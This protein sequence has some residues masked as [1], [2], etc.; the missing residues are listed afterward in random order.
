MGRPE[1]GAGDPPPDPTPDAA[2]D[3]ARSLTPASHMEVDPTMVDSHPPQHRSGD[4][5]SRQPSLSFL[6]DLPAAPPGRY[7][8]TDEI[9]RGGMGVVRGALDDLFGREVALK[10]LLDPLDDQLRARFLEE[11]RVTA[12]LEHPNVVPVH[13]M[14]VLPS[15]EVF[16]AMKRVRGRT[17]ADILDGI[18]EGDSDVA[19]EFSRV[20]LLTLFQQ[21]CMGVHYAHSRGVVHR[22]LKPDNLMVGEYGEVH[23]MDWGVARVLAREEVDVEVA[24]ATIAPTN[25]GMTSYGA[26]VGT[27]SYMPPEQAQGHHDK[28]GPH[29]DVYALGALLYEILT[30][31]PPFLERTPLATL[32]RVVTEVPIPPDERAPDRAIPDELGELCMRALAKAPHERPQSA[33]A[34][35]DAVEEFLEGTRERE[36]RRLEAARLSG[37]GQSALAAAARAVEEIR[38]L[39][40]QEG[41]LTEATDVLAPVED[42]RPLWATQ[43]RIRALEATRDRR[44]AESVQA[45]SEAVRN[46]RDLADANRA[47]ADYYWDRLSEAE[48]RRDR[49]AALH[50]RRLVLL[51]NRGDYDDFLRPTAPLLVTTEPAGATVMLHALAPVDRVFTPGPPQDLGTTPCEPVQVARGSYVLR[52]ECDGRAP[53][54]APVLV[55]RQARVEVFVRMYAPGEIGEGFIHIPGGPAILGNDPMATGG[56]VHRLVDVPDFAIAKRPVTCAEWVEFLNA[57]IDAGK[58]KEARYRAPKEVSGMGQYWAPGEDGRFSIPI[59]DRDGDV[60]ENDWPVGGVSYGDATRYC[61][62]YTQA[63]GVAVR[64]PT[65]DEWEKAARGVDGR[66]F[67]WG[68][69]FDPLFCKMRSSRQGRRTPE[70]CGAFLTDRSPYGVWDMAGSMRDWT[71]TSLEPG[72]RCAKGGA[73]SLP[74]GLCRPATSYERSESFAVPTTGFRLARDLPTG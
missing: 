38:E 11:A 16:F 55:G 32:M 71:S 69:E 25:S 37:Q 7:Q 26:V 51:H 68:D 74:S 10:Q 66:F 19:D 72:L 23:V 65:A 52:L 4:P 22:D 18:E 12:Q 73:W 64:L 60:W 15:G 70:V 42:K 24:A 2:A 29:S 8:S 45:F 63:K 3:P 6:L 13:D 17:L 62:W 46:D 1:S 57:L 58:E 34:L 44:I 36:R 67:P 27:P 5:T 41:R 40:Q 50:F 48:D 43:D 31:F 47:L 28:V 39:R 56:Q 20:R 21:V 33:R 59:T 35:F 30:G 54:T 14:G 53:V 49:T 61:E 9:G